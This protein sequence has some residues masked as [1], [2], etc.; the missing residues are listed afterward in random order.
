MILPF[1]AIEL[2]DLMAGSEAIIAARDGR[3][4]Y[5]KLREFKNR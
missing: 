5:W 4:K 3:R 1:L 2:S